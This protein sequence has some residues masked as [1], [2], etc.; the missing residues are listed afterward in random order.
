MDW[1]PE[2]I[3]GK[4]EYTEYIFHYILCKKWGELKKN[5][6]TSICLYK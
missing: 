1:F 5:V 4:A 6:Y 2:D 3:G